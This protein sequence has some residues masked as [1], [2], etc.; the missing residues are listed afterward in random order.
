[1]KLEIKNL[2][3]KA[4]RSGEFPQTSKKLEQNGSYCALGVLAAL[5]MLEGQ[6][7]YAPGGRFDNKRISLSH[8][9]MNWAEIHDSLCQF[10]DDSGDSFT[11]AEL[12]DNGMNFADIA[13]VIDKLWREL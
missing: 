13:D 3:T 5:A 7:T 11:I 9:I 10:E 1:M 4:L 2:W 6:C 12:N 8:N